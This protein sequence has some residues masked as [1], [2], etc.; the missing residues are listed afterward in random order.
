MIQIEAL[1]SAPIINLN[2]KERENRI[3]QIFEILN[4]L[5]DI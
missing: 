2:M 1:G 5:Y 3:H 4:D